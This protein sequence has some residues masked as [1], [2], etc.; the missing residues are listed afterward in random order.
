MAAV[1]GNLARTDQQWAG[2]PVPK[3]V[4]NIDSALLVATIITGLYKRVYQAAPTY[5]ECS[6]AL[7]CNPSYCVIG[8]LLSRI[9]Y[10]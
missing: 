6:L 10:L 8:Q 2:T 1:Y 3:V 7:N 9:Q 4:K 5:Q